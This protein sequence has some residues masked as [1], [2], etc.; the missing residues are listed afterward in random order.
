MSFDSKLQE[1]ENLKRQ[2][3]ARS[4]QL[5]SSGYMDGSLTLQAELQSVDIEL[6]KIDQ[7]LNRAMIKVQKIKIKWM[8]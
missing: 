7:I 2:C 4:T 1:I 5:A 8:V 6:A 3:Q